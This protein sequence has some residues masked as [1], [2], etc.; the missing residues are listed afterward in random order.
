LVGRGRDSP[1]ATG[2]RLLHQHSGLTDTQ[3]AERARQSARQQKW[4]PHRLRVLNQRRIGE[5][6]NGKGVPHDWETLNLVLRVLI[7]AVTRPEHPWPG[8]A[9]LLDDSENG[10]WRGWHA[11]AR[12]R[13]GS[14]DPGVRAAA[15]EQRRRY[16]RLPGA[17][18]HLFG[19]RD[20]IAGLLRLIGQHD[21]DGACDAVFAIAGMP[22]AGKTA[23]VLHVAH[24]VADRYPDGAIFLDL[25]GYHPD[26]PPMPPERALRHLLLAAGMHDKQIPAELIDLRATW[27]REAAGRR[28]LIVLDNAVDSQQLEPLLPS[29]PGCLF[30]VTSRRTLYDGLRDVRSVTLRILTDEAALD[31]LCSLAGP[32]LGQDDD[33]ARRIV[34]QCGSLPL[35]LMIAGALLRTP[36]YSPA[37]LAGDLEEE[38]HAFEEAPLADRD[39]SL[40][41]GVHASI[42]VSYQRLPD[43]LR[44]EFQLCGLFPGPGI[45]APA[46]AAMAGE[47]E[48]GDRESRITK[49]AVR[50]AGRSL[51]ELA[52]RNLLIPTGT[53]E[54]GARWKQH[55]L[56]RLS[57]RVCQQDEPLVDRGASVARLMDAQANTLKIINAWWSGAPP[58]NTRD[59][60]LQDFTSQ[61]QT[62]RWVM[63]ERA[64][65]LAS[66]DSGMPGAAMI[67]QYLGP[68]LRDIDTAM[69]VQDDENPATEPLD[70]YADARH[71]FEIQY[72]AAEHGGGQAGSVRAHA[73]RQIAA[74]ESAAARYDQAGQLYRKA[75]QVSRA[76]EDY[77]GLAM[78]FKGLGAIGRLTD[79][80]TLAQDSLGEAITFLELIHR[81]HP[82]QA[83]AAVQLADAMTELADIQS[84]LHKFNHALELLA[85]AAAV[86]RE[87]GNDLGLAR[88]H[89]QLG[90][91]R[92]L[93]GQFRAA[94]ECFTAAL[95]LYRKIDRPDMAAQ[96]Q[97]GLAQI[98]KDSG[99][100]AAAA[101]MFAE[102]AVLWKAWGDELQ[103]ARM[104]LGQAD[105][106]RLSSQWED[107]RRH[108]SQ[109]RDLCKRCQDREGEAEAHMGLGEIAVATGDG[110]ADTHFSD[111]TALYSQIG[112]PRASELTRSRNPRE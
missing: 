71:C 53:G 102:L 52:N 70:R 62:R 77:Y 56:V 8:Q 83:V 93:N 85:R 31:L 37:A 51:R 28:M 2:L 76:G 101:R 75:G 46:L 30:L 90:D 91:L 17:P 105:A 23:L 74:L 88:A 11:A 10:P 18:R 73:L 47:P 6:R 65:L 84:S 69:I 108:F 25:S 87:V 100:P 38:R 44:P 32:G 48:A 27:Q 103:Q 57:A 20:E 72:S 78:S 112:H 82:E 14:A 92:R 107:A 1:I 67:A 21:P 33:A 19:R 24:L 39:S 49:R 43:H 61:A 9:N 97:W 95:T 59:N 13:S 26:L 64:N 86:H 55:D 104:L 89:W 36:G 45:S 68:L 79:D 41:A 7:A 29:C 80:Y 109:A 54:F 35:A 34:E 106:E 66:A 111:A 60:V 16:C 42:M 4:P 81:S 50:L 58:L 40:H 3:I 5:W 99:D 96:A 22:G 63:A 12:R 15:L 94:R 98:E 110:P